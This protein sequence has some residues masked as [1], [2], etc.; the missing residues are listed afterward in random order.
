MEEEDKF[1]HFGC[2]NNTNIKIKDIKPKPIGCIEPVMKTLNSYLETTEKKP[3]FIVVA[4]DNYYPDK[5]KKEDDTKVKIIYPNKLIEGFDLLPK[6]IP[7]HMI[8]GNHDLETNGKKNSLFVN[9]TDTPELK[10]CAIINIEQD[11]IREKKREKL[12]IDYKLFNS[13]YLKNNT[14]LLMIDTSM[15][16]D[17]IEKFLPCYNRFL[18]RTFANSQELIEFQNHQIYETISRYLGRINNIIIIG[19]HPITGLKFKEEKIENEEIIPA[20]IELL[21]D[22]II[23]ENV[24]KEIYRMIGP[25]INYYYLCADLHMYQEGIVQLTLDDGSTMNINQYIVG[26]GGTKLDDVI[27]EDLEVPTRA[28]IN[29]IMNNVQYKC[30]FLECTIQDSGIIFNPI[31]LGEKI[32]ESKGSKGGKKTKK[33][34]KSRKGRKGKKTKKSKKSKKYS[35][36]NF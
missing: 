18:E 29:Y 13:K 24:L 27:P 12:N 19:H 23:F 36:N 32:K 6:E 17:D 30:G 31:L 10:D 3:N 11:V 25:D 33:N 7:I 28:G 22:I 15:Y 1:I 35:R 26:T 34:K 14:L 8:L 9:S 4:G 21:S 16:S 5:F 20:H 2:W